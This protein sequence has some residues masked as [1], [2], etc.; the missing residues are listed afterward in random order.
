MIKRLATAFDSA[1][2]VCADLR[3]AHLASHEAWKVGSK[4]VVA[5]ATSALHKH[6]SGPS[7]H[8]DVVEASSPPV[9]LDSEQHIHTV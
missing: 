5:S 6:F 8:F 7:G 2:G 1:I 9:E 3:A 4:S